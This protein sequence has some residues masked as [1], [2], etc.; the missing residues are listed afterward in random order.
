MRDTSGSSSPDPIVLPSSPLTGYS[1]VRRRGATS[2]LSIAG[3]TPSK[4]VIMYTPVARGQSPWR[5]KVTV[6]PEAS[7]ASGSPAKRRTT[8][9]VPNPESSPAK[10]SIED[11]QDDGEAHR[12][13]RKRRGT[14]MRPQRRAKE[15]V[16]HDFGDDNAGFVSL[17]PRPESAAVSASTRTRAAAR[18]VQSRTRRLTH[19]RGELDDAIRKAV[20][21]DH[22][23]DSALTSTPPA[24]EPDIEP[25]GDQTMANEDFTMILGDSLASIKANNSILTGFR[26]HSNFQHESHIEYP[27]LTERAVEA[28]RQAVG[29]QEEDEVKECLDTQHDAQ[30]YDVMSWQP[31]GSSMPPPPRRQSDGQ[32]CD[33]SSAM[34][35]SVQ[36]SHKATEEDIWAEEASRSLEDIAQQDSAE[37]RSV[38]FVPPIFSDEPQ[39]PR[40]SKIPRTWRRT[41]GADFSYADSPAVVALPPAENGKEA[42]KVESNRKWED[43]GRVLTPPSTDGENAF[44]LHQASMLSEIEQHQDDVDLTHPDAAATQLEHH[45]AHHQKQQIPDHGHARDASSPLSETSS[46]I[47]SADGEDG[48]DEDGEDTG[49]FW[50][51]NLPAL[52][53]RRPQRPRFDRRDDAVD[54]S[55]ILDMDSSSKL[56]ASKLSASGPSSLIESEA[57][58]GLGHLS[59]AA[60]RLQRVGNIK[61]SPL[62]MHAVHGRFSVAEPSATAGQILSSPLARSLLRSSKLGDASARGQG[63]VVSNVKVANMPQDDSALED[64]FASKA[65]D[66][67]QLLGEMHLTKHEYT[68]MDVDPDAGSSQVGEGEDSDDRVDEASYEDEGEPSKSYEEH[69]N[70]DSPTKVKVKFN[71][72]SLAGLNSE[73]LKPTRQ[74]APLFD[75]DPNIRRPIEF[76]PSQ[77]KKMTASPSP[78][79]AVAKRDVRSSVAKDANNGFLNRLSTSFWSAV[80]RPT[81]PIYVDP[82]PTAPPSTPSLQSQSPAEPVFPADLR[83]RIRSRYGVL[84]DHHP[85]TMTHMRTLHRMFNSLMSGKPDSVIPTRLPL[86]PHLAEVADT[87]QQSATGTPFLFTFQHACVAYTFMQVLVPPSLV[88]AMQRGE[89]EWLGDGIAEQYRGLMGSRGGDETC[90]ATVQGPEGPVAWDWVVGCVG[91]VISANEDTERRLRGRGD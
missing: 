15:V 58:T 84:S 69:L 67:R 72:S 60:V 59:T 28:Q 86:P 91:S 31:S 9:M 11:E 82:R 36:P 5:I 1:P 70:L 76:E 29:E 81:G 4:S 14:P 34:P 46:D 20:G 42:G 83:A 77:E 38:D 71:D 25:P 47:A 7:E 49:M 2:Q 52:Y 55:R 22:A 18:Q 45:L 87:T 24:A 63:L 64:S 6:E 85:W 88:R 33:D 12:V 89:V 3:A 17:S 66:E 41:S 78:A 57:K 56:D 40:R 23:G 65:S 54:L 62:Q 73:L 80:V 61:R 44:E 8:K 48:E 21:L 43:A 50:Q 90:F 26:E 10:R 32:S 51:S 13:P 68:S 39:P 16:H 35:F 27:D 79:T 19:A 75:R 53:S 74:Y 37:T 30:M